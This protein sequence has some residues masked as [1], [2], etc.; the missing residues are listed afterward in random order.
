MPVA[1]KTLL[2]TVFLW[3]APKWALAMPMVIRALGRRS[4]DM[5]S[6]GLARESVPEPASAA[7]LLLDQRLHKAAHRPMARRS[8]AASS[9]TSDCP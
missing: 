8:A 7:H 2:V 4:G 1:G 5:P 3:I 6:A 9:A